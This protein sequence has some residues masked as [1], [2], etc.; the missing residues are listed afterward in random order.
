MS[1][2]TSA[3][4]WSRRV[5]NWALGVCATFVAANCQTAHDPATGGETHF[6]RLC[7]STASSNGCGEELECL[8]D[9][10]TRACDANDACGGVSGMV[11]SAP[12]ESNACVLQSAARVCEF[13]CDSDSDCAA[14]SA[15]HR[16]RAGACRAPAP[17]GQTASCAT[18]QIEAGQVALLGDS[19]FALNHD[20]AE[21]LS[22]LARAQQVLP[23]DAQFR[24][25]S[26][27]VDNAL[28]VGGNGI[29][30]QYSDA[31][32][33]G[34]IKVVVTNGGGADLLVSACEE[35]VAECE[36]IASAAHAAEELFAV[37]AADGVRDI[38]YAFYPDPVDD[39]LR[40]KID[41]LR[42]MLEAACAAAPTRCHW[43]DLRTAFAGHPEYLD[44]DGMNPT[45]LGSEVAAGALWDILQQCFAE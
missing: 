28:I 10:C 31:V 34:D 36:V 8:C 13:R 26:R 45:P 7:D 12:S 5:R 39:E 2:S 16:C 19:F 23:E 9:V 42:P 37:M 35:P 32:S 24:D 41:A 6:L 43:L 21:Q 11:C 29:A 38:V 3:S 40:T 22:A 15:E 44:N 4:P 25:Y 33:E 20:I 17:L 1:K 18:G 27:L 14:L 30:D